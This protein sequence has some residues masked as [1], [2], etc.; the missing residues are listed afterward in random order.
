MPSENADKTQAVAVVLDWLGRSAPPLSCGVSWGVPWP[1][2]AV[3]QDQTFTL[4]TGDGGE[5][6]LQSWPLAYWPDG[7]LKWS[8]FATVTGSQTAGPLELVPGGAESAGGISVVR[9]EESG[10]AIQIDTGCLQCRIPRQG[11]ILVESLAVDGRRVATQG[12]LVCIL[13]EG[14]DGDVD[15]APSREKFVGRIQNVAVEQSG[16]VRAV[17]KFAGV[18]QAKKGSRE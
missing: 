16:P 6:P 4:N 13:Q 11:N 3:R 18:H 7:S 1:R 12:R 8:G 14:P 9:V 5:L 10:E 2:G 15:Q 17:V